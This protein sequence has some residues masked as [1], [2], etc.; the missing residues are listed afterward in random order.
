MGS[1]SVEHK[2]LVIWSLFGVL[3][4][5]YHTPYILVENLYT[6]IF[7]L[8]WH[9][10]SFSVSWRT[11]HGVPRILCTGLIICLCVLPTTAC[12]YLQ[13]WAETHWLQNLLCILKQGLSTVLLPTRCSGKCWLSQMWT[14]SI[15]SGPKMFFASQA[16]E[17]FLRSSLKRKWETAFVYRNEYLNKVLFWRTI[18]SRKWTEWRHLPLKPFRVPATARSSLASNGSSVQQDFF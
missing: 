7:H 13:H 16:S 3:Y 1:N 12:D 18:L 17:M 15:F 14:V 4:P 11:L 5:S 10:N 2:T 9:T 6:H 8:F